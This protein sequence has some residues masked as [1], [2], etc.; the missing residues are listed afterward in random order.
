MDLLLIV[1]MMMLQFECHLDFF[2]QTRKNTRKGIL[3]IDV[4]LARFCESGLFCMISLLFYN[5]FFFSVLDFTYI[6]FFASL[7]ILKAAL[8]LVFEV[9][10]I[11]I[12]VL[13]MMLYCSPC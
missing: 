9:R 10:L 5:I 7:D 2:Q 6:F 3:Y 11:E 4:V 12:H 8:F 13:L 1:T